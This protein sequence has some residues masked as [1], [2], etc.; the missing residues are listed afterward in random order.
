[1]SQLPLLSYLSGRLGALRREESGAVGWL[2]VG[3]ILGAIR[4][5]V[6]IIKLLIP[7]D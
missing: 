6:L 3:V 5:V 4:V 7:G 2:V 1:M